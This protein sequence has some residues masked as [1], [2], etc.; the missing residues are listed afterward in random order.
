MQV[1]RVK[2]V[3]LSRSNICRKTLVA[4]T[5]SMQYPY[6]VPFYESIYQ[7]ACMNEA[8]SDNRQFHFKS[9]LIILTF[10]F[11]NIRLKCKSLISSKAADEGN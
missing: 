5:M 10:L 11:M 1:A 3:R 8:L 6:Y 7:Y 4:T 9:C 2:T